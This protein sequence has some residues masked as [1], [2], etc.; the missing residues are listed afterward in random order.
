MKTII[1]FDFD[2]TLADS[3]ALCTTQVS[4]A[5]K[6][7]G[8]KPVS[9]ELLMACNGPS[10]DEAAI[11]LGVP[12]DMRAHFCDVRRGIEIS[13]I[14]ETQKLFGGVVNLLESLQGKAQLA[15]VSNGMGDYLNQSL[16]KF[17]LRK[18][19][20]FVQPLIQG[21]TKGETLKQLVEQH[22]PEKALMVGDRIGDI[23]AGQF[24]GISTLAAA[25]GF[26][27]EEEYAKADARV[28][29]IEQLKQ[30]LLNFIG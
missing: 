10:Y 5:L 24:A 20:A 8:L 28:E 11:L 25:Y 14:D 21:Q 26:G 19:F 2:G 17:G 30:Y 27:S 3:M 12:E 22:K 16:D 18:Y 15:L 9:Q 7:C 6:A 29:S 13:I 23:Q 4:R 1:Y